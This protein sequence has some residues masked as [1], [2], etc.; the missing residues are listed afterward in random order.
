MADLNVKYIKI[1]LSKNNVIYNEVKGLVVDNCHINHRNF[2]NHKGL[3]NYLN[4]FNYEKETGKEGN[5]LLPILGIKYP[6]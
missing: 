6:K 5:F 2:L 3:I 1:N 4:R